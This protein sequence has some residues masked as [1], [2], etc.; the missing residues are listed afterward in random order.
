MQWQNEI[1]DYYAEQAKRNT[2]KG[3]GW[4]WSEGAGGGGGGNTI[5]ARKTGQGR[6]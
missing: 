2:R 6:K 5:K 3:V 1:G 4:G